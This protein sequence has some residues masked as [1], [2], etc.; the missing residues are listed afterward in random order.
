MATANL[1]LML[2]ARSWQGRERISLGLP[3]KS[4]KKYHYFSLILN[5]ASINQSVWP[6]ERIIWIDWGHKALCLSQ[7]WGPAKISTLGRQGFPQTGTR[8]WWRVEGWLHGGRWREQLSANSCGLT[9]L[10][11]NGNP[12]GM[13]IYQDQGKYTERQTLENRCLHPSLDINILN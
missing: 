11:C 13:R 1:G 3:L 8:V 5:E 10:V 2:K 4:R 7:G 12:I 9:Q 6:G